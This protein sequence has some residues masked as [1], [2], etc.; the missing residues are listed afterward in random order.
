MRIKLCKHLLLI[1]VLVAGVTACDDGSDG[2]QG[3]QGEQG[4][5]GSDGQD[6]TN[7]DLATSIDIGPYQC[8]E[9]EQAENPN[10]NCRLYIKGSMNSWSARPEAELTHQGNGIY[11]A[12]FR[13]SPGD[14]SFKISDPDWSPERDIAIGTDVAADVVFDVPML[15]Q[16]KYTADDGTEY[17][18]QNMDISV[19]GDEDQVFR[20][21]LDA[22]E[23]INQPPL[24][25]ENV[26]ETDSSDLTKPLYL[27]GTFNN[28]SAHQD[29]L[30]N[31]VGAGGYEVVVAFEDPQFISF[32][33]Q[34]GDEYGN[35]YGSLKDTPLT[36]ENGSSVLTTYPGG[37][38]AAEVEA[39]VYVFNISMLGDSQIGVPVSMNK[40]RATAGHDQIAV[41]N[42]ATNLTADGSLF[43]DSFSWATSGT[44]TPTLISDAT[45]SQTDTR[46]NATA[47]T[48]G[49]FDAALTI[50]ADTETEAL[51]TVSIEVVDAAPA[52]N[53]IFFIGDGMGFPQIEAARHFNG[54]TLAMEQAPANAE[55]YTASA[56]T[57]GYE[58]DEHHGDNYYTDSAA[59]ATAFATGHK[60]TSGT[61]SVAQPGNGDD[62]PTIMEYAKANGMS[63]GVVATS[64]CAHATPAAFVAHGPN[65]SDYEALSISIYQEV[66]PNLTLCGTRTYDR[67]DD[68][69]TV[70]ATAGGY[71]VVN[72]ETALNAVT[73]DT[74]TFGNNNFKFAGIFGPQDFSN[75][76]SG[77]PYVLPLEEQANN[78][79]TYEAYDIPTLAEMSAKAIE[80]LSQ[81]P[82]GFV[83]M[84]EG[85]QIDWAGHVNLIEQN[86]QETIAMD[87]AVAEAI[88]WTTNRTDT[89]LL[90]TADHEC[91]GLEVQK[92][93]GA[94]IYPDVTWKWGSH[95]NVNVPLMAWGVNANIFNDK[96]IDNTSIFN[97]M[98]GAIQ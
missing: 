34:Q 28:W 92:D 83:L 38:I 18:N 77:I 78:G 26:T 46:V 43:A 42:Q 89:M 12:L 75:N 44:V 91:G 45:Q 54:S 15:M 76:S 49:Q 67:T 74:A 61:I 57:L 53:V 23:T 81:N 47:P 68:M 1:L 98:L 30:F 70:N 60:A 25:L 80:I 86:V 52:K 31:Y 7:P 72:T 17:S 32:K 58:L 56:D 64:D 13:M 20:F 19:T 8:T 21:T 48:T 5:P 33:I 96:T 84:V 24:L 55:I 40:V 97:V 62:Y 94:G 73:V 36:L 9:D 10:K 2:D 69:H 3:I 14:Y 87:E 29:F 93:N 82:N 27:V 37:N 16:R 22:S 50:N 65:R 90:V 6:L 71:T 39:G 4:T 79:H 51:D 11:I 85:S 66:Q 35:K 59:A 95:T 88:A 41:T 63:V